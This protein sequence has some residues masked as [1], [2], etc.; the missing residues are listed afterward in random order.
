MSER[1]STC[2]NCEI[3]AKARKANLVKNAE[4][5]YGKAPADEY[6]ELREK[7]KKDL[8][9]NDTLSQISSVYLDETT[10][11]L[12]LKFKCECSVCGFIRNYNK[13]IN[14]LEDEC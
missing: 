1:K 13:K 4:K 11:Q 3:T 2:P 12:N 9:L 8:Y 14:L 7:S 5:A 6:V 10:G